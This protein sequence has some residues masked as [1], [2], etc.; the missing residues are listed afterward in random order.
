MKRYL[1]NLKVISKGLLYFGLQLLVTGISG[2]G[3]CQPTFQRLYGSLDNDKGFSITQCSSGGYLVSGSAT[4][5]YTL[6]PDLYLIRITENGDTIWTR[7]ISNPNVWDENAI[8]NEHSDHSFIVGNY[9]ATDS[10]HISIHKYNDQGSE[11]WTQSYYIGYQSFLSSLTTTPFDSDITFCGSFNASWP[12]WSSIFVIK[13]NTDGDELWRRTFSGSY[14][15]SYYSQRIETTIDNGLIVCGSV[16]YPEFDPDK[17]LLI[18]ISSDGQIQWMKEYYS[19]QTGRSFYISDC[20]QLPDSTYMVI[21]VTYDA[22][23]YE[24]KRPVLMRIDKYGN[25]MW[26]KQFDLL[27]H[28][29]NS[30]LTDNTDTIII[31]GP[32]NA[33][34]QILKTNLDGEITD[35]I[36]FGYDFEVALNQ[37]IISHDNGYIMTGAASVSSGYGGN[38]VVIIKANQDGIITRIPVIKSTEDGTELKVWPN[39]CTEKIE[40][41]SN[42]IIVSLSISDSKGIGLYKSREGTDFRTGQIINTSSFPKG[43]LFIRGI[44]NHGVFSQ[45]FIK[46]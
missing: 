1:S 39:P 31:A 12:L 5:F 7:T 14:V 43:M 8:V 13:T 22:F 9:S 44:T 35:S 4:N 2:N 41:K 11:L 16:D 38:D 26:F 6:D 24:N 3:Y 17:G 27:D 36:T 23:M 20:K 37:T 29:Y 42:C 15:K 30:I 40:V 25:S 45:K 28:T 21:G 19:Q 33:T 32:G 18:K 46:L 34:A 10:S